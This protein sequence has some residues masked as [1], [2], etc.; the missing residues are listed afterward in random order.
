[1]AT[2]ARCCKLPVSDPEQTRRIAAMR[3]HPRSNISPTDSRFSANLFAVRELCRN[4]ALS[5]HA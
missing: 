1:M 2:T 4:A 5:A 3:K